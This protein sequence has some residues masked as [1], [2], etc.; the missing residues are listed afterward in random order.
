MIQFG[1]SMGADSKSFLGTAG[2]GDLIATAT[3]ENSRNYSFGKKLASEGG[4]ADQIIKSI[5]EVVEGVNTLK[6]IHLLAK[7]EALQ[8][9]ITNM[10]YRVVYED[11]PVDK[12]LRLSNHHL[13]VVVIF[14][15]SSLN[16]KSNN[17]GCWFHNNTPHIGLICVL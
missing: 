5:G 7:K 3:S 10:L 9:P 13:Q 12:A 8:L 15:V 17:T 2:I 4:T 11:F 6:I 16:P 14:L 1:Q